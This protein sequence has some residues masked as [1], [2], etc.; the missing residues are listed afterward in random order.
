MVSDA[1]AAY[2]S[3]MGEVPWPGER[4][5]RDWTLYALGATLAELCGQTDGNETDLVLVPRGYD[6]RDHR[7]LV[8]SNLLKAQVTPE[9]YRKL[10]FDPTSS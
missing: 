6:G 4:A 9:F 7:I 3:H 10:H 5:G 1:P 8:V 2:Q